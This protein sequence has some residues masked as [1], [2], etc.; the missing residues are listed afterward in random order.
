VLR[1][2]LLE[3]EA[4]EPAVG[5]VQMY[6]LAQPALGPYGKAVTDDQLRIINS[7]SIEGRPVWL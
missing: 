3:A 1:Y 2:G 7:G 4:A 6:F 5:E